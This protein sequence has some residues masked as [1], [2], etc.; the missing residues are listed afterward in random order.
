M[1]VLKTCGLYVLTVMQQLSH[2]KEEIKEM[3]ESLWDY[4]YIRRL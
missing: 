4:L 2:G 3:E 1:T